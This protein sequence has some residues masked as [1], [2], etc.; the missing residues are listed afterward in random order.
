[1]GF[2]NRFL[3]TPDGLY[4]R[5]GKIGGLA[6]GIFGT[7]AMGAFASVLAT[8]HPI[9]LGPPTPVQVYTNF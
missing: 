1:M 6:F 5:R 7:L 9:D 2:L 3:P 4:K 8:G